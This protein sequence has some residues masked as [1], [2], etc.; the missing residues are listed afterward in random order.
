[1]L[2]LVYG[3][4]VSGKSAINCL[5]KLGRQVAIYNDSPVEV[6]EDVINRCG[7]EINEV[8]EDVSLIVISPSVG[9]NCELLKVAKTKKI[10][11][12]GELE[13]GYRNT[14]G[15]LI[16]ITGTNGKTTCTELVTKMLKDAGLKADYYGNIGVPLAENSFNITEEKVG[17]VEVSSFQ[18]ASCELFCP[19]IAICLNIADDHLEYHKTMNEYIK[20]KMGIF[21]NQDKSEYAVL[22]YDD[23]I[24]KNF[25]HKI[26][27]NVYYFSLS[28]KV[29]GAY[30]KGHS[31]YFCADSPEY[32]CDISDINIQGEHNISNCLACITACKILN[33][34]NNIIVNSL[35]EFELSS[36]RLQ[37]VNTIKG[38]K[39]FDDSK[40]TNISS[41]ISA[42]KSMNGKTTLLI[43]GYDKGLDYRKLFKELPIKITTIICY[44]ENRDKI[45]KDSFKSFATTI[46]KADSLEDAIEIAS[47]VCCDNVLFSPATSSFDRFKNYIERGNFFRDYLK[48][49]EI[50]EI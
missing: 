45:V 4:G 22:N 19:K 5:L 36:H 11:I 46:I 35:K 29:K 1:M 12:I 3:Y 42:C 40:S 41:T 28:H 49:L 2:T 34:P 23:E 26:H 18:L 14:L 30:K 43:G 37:L 7:L 33:M 16:A 50:A 6:T 44:G 32:I 27:S 38:V 17:V 20:C 15:D 31:I 13:L 24:V 48:R 39:Y 10:E 21:K 25:A 47:K 8:L 9:L